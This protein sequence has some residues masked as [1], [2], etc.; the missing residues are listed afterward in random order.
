MKGERER[1]QEKMRKRAGR[2]KRREGWLEQRQ[3]L[4]RTEGERERHQVRELKERRKG[5]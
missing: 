3:E 2:E 5:S 1:L 4:K